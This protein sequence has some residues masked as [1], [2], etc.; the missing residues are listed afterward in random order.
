MDIDLKGSS[1]ILAT[2]KVKALY[3]GVKILAISMHGE[4]NYIMKMI[5]AG[6]TGYILKNAGKDEMLMAIES[7]VKGGS[8]FSS[9]VSAE[10]FKQLQQHSD[11]T[12]AEHQAPLTKREVEILRLIAQEFSNA[13][14][15][16]KLFISI[17]T[18]DTHR[19]NLIEK[20]EVKNTA[21]LVRY[22]LKNGLAE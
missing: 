1:G 2:Q 3:P 16:E 15:A 6:A 13:E 14:I 19:R 9:D 18:V 17:R 20:L 7:V 8:Y 4:H 21:G 5:E 10:L 12:K 22:A 11:K